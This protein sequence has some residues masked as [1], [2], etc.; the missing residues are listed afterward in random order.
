MF[1]TNVLTSNLFFSTLIT[2]VAVVVLFTVH[3]HNIQVK[4]APIFFDEPVTIQRISP[5]AKAANLSVAKEV[6]LAESSPAAKPIETVPPVLMPPTVLVRILPAFPVSALEKGIQG[7]VLLSVYVG[8]S[9]LPEKVET[10]VSSGNEDIDRSAVESVSQ[11][12]FEPA[13]RGIQTI[14]SWFEVPVVFKIK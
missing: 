4:S 1:K 8:T 9:G 5:A 2:A 12:K 11:W 3:E 13:R 6:S 7:T 10:K 14:G